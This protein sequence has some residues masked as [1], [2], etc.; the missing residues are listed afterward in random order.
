VPLDPGPY[1][2]RKAP[3]RKTRLLREFARLEGDPNPGGSTRSNGLMTAYRQDA[4]RCL[5][6]L[7][8][9]GPTKAAIVAKRAGVA[10]AR[11][12]MADNHYGWFERVETGIYAPSPNGM[13]ASDQFARDIARLC[14]A[15]RSG[16]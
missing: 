12:L 1:A 2:P 11:R 13:R 4:L 15:D 6:V 5:R 9:D 8:V 14:C 10:G 16:S 7:V 3:R